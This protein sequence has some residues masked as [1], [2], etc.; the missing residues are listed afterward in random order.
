M[1]VTQSRKLVKG[2]FGAGREAISKTVSYYASFIVLGLATAVIGPTLPWLAEHTQSRLSEVSYLFTANSF[3][4][5]LGS[6]LGGRLYDR[7]SGHPLMTTALLTTL[8]MLALFPLIPLLWALILVILVIGFS[9]AFID[10][11][12]NT[13]LM[14]VHGSSVGP[15]MS[16]L[17]FFFGLGALLSPVIVAQVLRVWG[18]VQWTYW[19]LALVGIPA[20]LTV[21]RLPSPEIQAFS[22]EGKAPGDSLFVLLMSFFFFLH[23]GAEL[24]FGGWIYTYAVRR[25]L[26]NEAAAAYLTSLFWGTFTLGRLLGVPLATLLKPRFILICDLAGCMLGV[27]VLLLFSSSPFVLW[28]GTILAG[29]S[30]ATIFPTSFTFSE[31]HIHMSGRVTSFFLIGASLGTMFLPWFI[32]QLFERTGPWV[33]MGILLLDLLAAL[34]VLLFLLRHAARLKRT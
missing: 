29:I 31:R 12:G 21:L 13:L 7:T 3:G 2:R 19:I 34:V 25:G 23:V 17:H 10:V 14:R 16:G 30:I 5:L 15:F 9:S 1:D 33:T 22:G 32:G 8:A 4:Y 28:A 26:A 11:G 6:L 20:A 18:Q 24:S 27:G